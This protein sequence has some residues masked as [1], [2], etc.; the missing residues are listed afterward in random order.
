MRKWKKERER[1]TKAE[2]FPKYDYK[3]ETER[4]RTKARESRTESEQF[5]SYEK[6]EEKG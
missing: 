5:S 6:E 3:E 2:Q 4:N 1:K